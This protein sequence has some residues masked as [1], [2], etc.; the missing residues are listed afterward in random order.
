MMPLL[1]GSQW[2][3]SISDS[4]LQEMPSQY[5]R[6]CVKYISY[7][8]RLFIQAEGG[9]G[10]LAQKTCGGPMIPCA[11][12]EDTGT[13][14]EMSDTVYCFPQEGEEKCCAIDADVTAGP[15][16]RPKC[17]KMAVYNYSNPEDWGNQFKGPGME[18]GM[19]NGSPI[20]IVTTDVKKVPVVGEPI[21]LEG[22]HD[23]FKGTLCDNGYNLRL[24]IQDKRTYTLHHPNGFAQPYA[25]QHIE[26]HFGANMASDTKGSE[27]SIDGKYSHMEMQM[28]FFDRRNK[29]YGTALNKSGQ[30]TVLSILYEVGEPNERLYELVEHLKSYKA[31]TEKTGSM[32]DL[33]THANLKEGNSSFYYYRGSMNHP[34]R[35][36][37]GIWWTV[38]LNKET[39]S[40]EQFEVFQ[41]LRGLGG[42]S[43]AGKN[44]P[45]Q[46]NE[47]TVNH[48]GP[49]LGTTT[50]TTTTSTTTTTTTTT[51]PAGTTTTGTGGVTGV[52]PEETTKPQATDGGDSVTTAPSVTGA[53]ED[54]YPMTTPPGAEFDAGYD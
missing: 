52:P 18:C 33:F 47:N 5:Q 49:N 38:L 26:W 22:H 36:K 39:I 9:Y 46:K 32:G 2:M 54:D 25:L 53:P 15:P 28:V 12:K 21:R 4:G 14:G 50:T 37:Q 45:V 6:S 16:P 31:G 30:V 13:G 27:H 8:D 3:D 24:E 11:Y 23:G 41:A 51:K 17:G 48:H 7:D 1:V 35:C 29:D 19:P 42:N 34:P 10:E 43:L 44:R 40:I 20:N